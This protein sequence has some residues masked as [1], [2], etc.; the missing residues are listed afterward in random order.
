MSVNQIR[1]TLEEVAAERL[2]QVDKWG[3]QN[4]PDGTGSDLRLLDDDGDGSFPAI[5]Q[6][7][8]NAN[9]RDIARNRCD[10][11]HKAGN[12]TWEQILTEEYAEAI[13]ESDPAKLRTE[14]IQVAAVACA[15]VESIDRRTA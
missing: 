13:A 15:W 4:H 12:G 7:D 8:T 1:P 2:A 6:A 11:M 14:L 9:V 3:H 5:W 10:A